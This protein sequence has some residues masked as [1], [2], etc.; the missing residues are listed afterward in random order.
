MIR[1]KTPDEIIIMKE[2]GAILGAILKSV[3]SA[4]KPGVDTHTLEKMAA[5]AMKEYNVEPLFKGFEGYPAV[6]CMSVNEQVVHGLPRSD[7]TLEHGDIISID[8]GIRY[9]GLCLDSALT[10]P[11]GKISPELKKLLEVTRR[12]L[13]IGIEQARVGNSIGDIGYAIESFVKKQGQYGIIKQL[14]GHGIGHSL[15]EE[16]QVPNFGSP[17]DGIALQPGLVIAIEPMISLGSDQ[18]V[19]SDDGWTIATADNSISAHF[20][21]TVAI[22]PDGPQV[23]TSR[24]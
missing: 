14:V 3:A 1:Y 9:K 15:H 13:D 4:V 23:L 16:P 18:I 2:G 7:T 20:E 8:A 24:A 10:V 19:T 6:T 11:V 21:H 22:T 17:G 5:D 12:S